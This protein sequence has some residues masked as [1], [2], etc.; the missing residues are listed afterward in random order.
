M[1]ETDATVL[2]IQ[3]VSKDNSR[4]LIDS[5][6]GSS[7]LAQQV[8]LALSLSGEPARREVSS[9][10]LQN[11]NCRAIQ[12]IGRYPIQDAFAVELKEGH[13]E[14]S[15]FKEEQGTLEDASTFLTGYLADGPKPSTEMFLEAQKVGVGKGPL[16]DIRE[17][18][19]ITC[20]KI[21]RN[22]V[23]ALPQVNLL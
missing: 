4:G 22:W 21:G 14:R 13:F 2:I 6:M 15:A 3:H 10:K 8:D 18:L 5:G 9:R 20:S 1:A 19:G 16:Y 17:T 23:W 11:E 7:A 12:G